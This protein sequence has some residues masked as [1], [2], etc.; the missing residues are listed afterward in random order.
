MSANQTRLKLPVRLDLKVVASHDPVDGTM[1]L[2]SI[3]RLLGGSLAAF[4]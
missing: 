3:V 4:T 2:M 1:R